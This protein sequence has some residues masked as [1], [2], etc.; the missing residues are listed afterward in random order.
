VDTY[1]E[2]AAYARERA[3][4][5]SAKAEHERRCANVHDAGEAVHLRAMRL[6]LDAARIQVYASGCYER[7]A[8]AEAQ[9]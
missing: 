7:L 3:T 6:H 2:R 8:R 9:P 5:E 4:I 1:A